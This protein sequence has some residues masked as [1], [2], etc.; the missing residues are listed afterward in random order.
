[1]NKAIPTILFLMPFYSQ[2]AFHCEVTVKR[3]LAYGNGAVNV[4]HTGRNDYTY[5]CNLSTEYKGVS[6]T[7]CAMWTSMLQNI[8]SKKNKAI[9]YYDGTG[10]C[11][12]LP[13]YGNTPAPVYIGTTEVS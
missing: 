6:I 4:I 7:T 3:V 13:T 1:M 5:I 12:E 8:Q 2:A 9:F 11:S 10:S